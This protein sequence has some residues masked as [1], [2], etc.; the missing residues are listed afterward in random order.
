MKLCREDYHRLYDQ[1]SSEF[2]L[3]R[4][5]FYRLPGLFGRAKACFCG[6]FGRNSSSIVAAEIS[7]GS[8]ASS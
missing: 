3:D 2:M 7:D 8:D 5:K 6:S 1:A 4:G